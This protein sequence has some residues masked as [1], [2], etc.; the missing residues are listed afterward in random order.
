MLKRRTTLLTLPALLLGSEA[1]AVI[2]DGNG[3]PVTTTG[4][5][6]TFSGLNVSTGG[7]ATG[8]TAFRIADMMEMFGFNIFPDDGSG[9]TY[10]SSPAVYTLASVTAAYNF[11][12][13]GSGMILKSRAWNYMSYAILSPYCPALAIA[14]GTQFTMETGGT[15]DPG[16]TGACVTLANESHASSGHSAGAPK[17]FAWSDGNNE[18]NG[19]GG[20]TNDE[21]L[22]CNQAIHTGVSGFSEIQVMSP[23]IVIGLPFPEGYISGYLGSDQAALAATCTIWNVHYYPSQNPSF[24]DN[25]S[26]GG[27]LADV[28][29][30]TNIGYGA[31]KPQFITEYHPTLFMT[32]NPNYGTS[33]WSAAYDAY[34]LPIGLL[35]AYRNG[36]LGFIWYALYDFGSVYT[37]GFWATNAQSDIARPPAYT[38]QAM[39]K[40]TGDSGSTKHTFTA[41][42]LNF[43]VSGLQPVVNSLSPHSGGQSMLFQN[44]T[45]TFFLF[46]WNSQA[47]PGGSASTVTI[48]FNSVAMTTVKDY[49]I[50]NATS[51]AAPTTA[52]QNLSNVTTMTVS[53]NASVHLLV[54]THP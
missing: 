53:L 21:T 31:T 25:S 6:P 46:L 49:I 42:K 28:V 48:S 45:G 44:S 11:I 15:V 41:K 5:L 50:S 14:T 1:N 26:R 9:N 16:T 39:F 27:E 34:F 3:N 18:P 2:K 10:G 4:S 7:D 43:S 33:G 40:L 19:I 17:W 23:S 29:Q 36:F 8:T 32:G 47:A 20:E 13:S 12:T 51:S 37:T 52:V 54:I 38:M 35:E 22:A 24:D 30:G